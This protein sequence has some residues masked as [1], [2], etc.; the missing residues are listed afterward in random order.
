MDANKRRAHINGLVKKTVLSIYNQGDVCFQELCESL[1]LSEIPNITDEITVMDLVR[2]YAE[3]SNEID[4][5]Q[6][7]RVNLDHDVCENLSSEQV[8][9][10]ISTGGSNG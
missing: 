7:I 10:I 8:V 1:P 6:V 2:I 4:G 3:L 5:D 9:K